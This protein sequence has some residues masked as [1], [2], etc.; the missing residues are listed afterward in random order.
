M[1]G[2]M[3]MKKWIA[4]FIAFALMFALCACNNNDATHETEGS[5]VNNKTEFSIPEVGAQGGYKIATEQIAIVAY[6]T[7]DC[8][9][10]E[11]SSKDGS[12]L[13]CYITPTEM[14]VVD[15]ANGETT[16]YKETFDTD[17]TYTNPLTRIFGSM[18]NMD[19]AE[20]SEGSGI[21]RA[22]IKTEQEVSKVIK[23]N[24]YEIKMTWTDNK[25]YVFEYFDYANG[26]NIVSADAPDEINPA[27]TKDT[28]WIVDVDSCVV[29]NTATNTS[30][31]FTVTKI[32]AEEGASP[33]G[34][35]KETITKEFTIE[36]T[37]D[38]KFEINKVRY[39]STNLDLNIDILY[40]FDM[41]KPVIPDGAREMT[42]DEAQDALFRVYA[43]ESII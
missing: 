20:T 14:I 40:N 36:L 27:I 23:Y 28:T 21:Y 38:E 31:P 2:N 24:R 18:K 12:C 42:T 8:K 39:L 35:E 17:Q 11:M 1:K 10:V 25:E 29:T 43:A 34:T 5:S 4:L 3:L 30:V 7:G 26:E 13:Q 22:E 15:T 19:F 32:V 37:V 41:V 33:S 9:Y 16:Y 6:T